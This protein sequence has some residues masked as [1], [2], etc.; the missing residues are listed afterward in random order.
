[1]KP[2]EMDN[3]NGQNILINFKLFKQLQFYQIFHSSGMKII[4]WNIHQ[5]FYIVYAL[6]GLCIECYGISTLFS[7][8]CKFLSYT[9]YVL[10]SYGT[11]NMFLSYWKLFKCL[12]DRNRLL[13]LFEIAQLNFLTSEKCAKYSKILYKHSDKNLKFTN[14]FLIFS[15]M[16]I[17]QWFIFPI[18]INQIINFEN[19]NV[20]AQNI[21][22]FCF[23]VSAQTYNKYFLIFYLLEIVP[24]S[25][26]VYILLMMDT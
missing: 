9:D 17:I 14:Y 24:A 2:H 6:V 10:I 13:D 4:G 19:S 25:I 23:G 26:T 18:V 1:M 12:K 20:R 21:I 8:N 16:V 11:S 22:N 3:L 7:T 5:L 15:F